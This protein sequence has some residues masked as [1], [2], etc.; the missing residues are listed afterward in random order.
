LR[1]II[2]R[3]LDGEPDSIK[4][5][6]LGIEVFGRNPSYDTTDDPIVRVTASK[7]R[8]RISKYYEDPKHQGELRLSFPAGSYVPVFER[9]EE[10]TAKELEPS[11]ANSIDTLVDPAES[12]ELHTNA[13]ELTEPHLM[14]DEPG[15][16]P[17]QR[18][19]SPSRRNWALV[20]G[21]ATIILAAIVSGLTLRSHHSD[22]SADFWRS[23]LLS[24]Q[25]V[26]LCIADEPKGSTVLMMDPLNP[27]LPEVAGRT[28]SI[29]DVENVL[30]VADLTNMIASRRQ[31][32]SV[33]GQRKTTLTDL[34]KGPDVLFGAFN[35]IWTLRFTK[36]LRFHLA[37]DPTAEASWI[38]DRNAP[39]DRKW[40]RDKRMVATDTGRDYALVAR[41][42][43]PDTGQPTIVVAGLSHNS[44]NAAVGCLLSA[45]CLGQLDQAAPSD[46]RKR[47]L[48]F[49]LEMSS[50]DGKAGRPVISTATTW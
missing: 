34:S 28:P 16:L 48:E 7:I 3:V 29:I 35:N 8:K 33:Q 10:D 6:T 11:R 49:V 43:S 1:F 22:A 46:W 42:T 21:A 24:P 32:F 45:E 15:P 19:R 13:T 40:M 47:N 38:E 31:R 9:F 12:V 5:R 4:E 2:Q 41:F 37:A 39:A 36:N 50:V 14:A 25:P 44:N 30:P 27:T 20:G 26:L 18:F 23:A 17:L